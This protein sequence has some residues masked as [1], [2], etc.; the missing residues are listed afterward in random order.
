M[1]KIL[2]SLTIFSALIFS[3]QSFAQNG[4][5]ADSSFGAPSFS[6]GGFVVEE[7]FQKPS[8]GENVGF[9]EVFDNQDKKDAGKSSKITHSSGLYA[10]AGLG[11]GGGFFYKL[12][13]PALTPVPSYLF[14]VSGGV[15]S[16]FISRFGA[17]NIF[18]AVDNVA[19][20]N[21]IPASVKFAKFDLGLNLRSGMNAFFVNPMIY[22]NADFTIPDTGVHFKLTGNIGT[23]DFLN[24]DFKFSVAYEMDFLKSK[25]IPGFEFGGKF[26]SASGPFY[27]SRMNDMYMGSYINLYLKF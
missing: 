6:G 21:L 1:K 23:A 10:I 11:F 18:L 4:F 3:S 16:F 17:G 14:D 2:I 27:F 19:F 12:E 24:H 15:G 22:F 13:Q 5:G 9:G 26:Y 25:V 20:W 8:F 7:G